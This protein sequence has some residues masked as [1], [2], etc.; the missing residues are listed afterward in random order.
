MAWVWRFTT[1]YTWYRQATYGETSWFYSLD[2]DGNCAAPGQC[3][4]H[5]K[6]RS[7]DFFSYYFI[8]GNTA[9][10]PSVSNTGNNAAMNPIPLNDGPH[11]R[12]M[13]WVAWTNRITG[14]GY[15][16]DDIYWDVR[17]PSPTPAR[18]RIS[19]AL[20]REGLEDYEVFDF[21]LDLFHLL[22]PVFISSK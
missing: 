22:F 5:N 11:Y 21:T 9:F 12:V 10:A 6:L 13:P 4:Y 18:P 17:W 14:W 8:K 20:L 19:A 16:H 15:Y 2:T 1:S 3:K 7:L